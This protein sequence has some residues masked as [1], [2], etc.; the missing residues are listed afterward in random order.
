MRGTIRLIEHL[1]ETLDRF[2]SAFYNLNR[3][4]DGK[5]VLNMAE[6]RIFLQNAMKASEI[7]RNINE[8]GGYA[9]AFEREQRIFLTEFKKMKA[10]A[11]NE[12]LK[13]EQ[14]SS[15]DKVR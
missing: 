2:S 1:V 6:E 11:E 14:Q 5:S 13:R 3:F 9:E 10:E 8:K 12:A 4:K 7:Y 15:G